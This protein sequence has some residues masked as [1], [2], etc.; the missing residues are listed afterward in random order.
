MFGRD[1]RQAE[2]WDNFIKKKGQASGMLDWKLLAGEAGGWLTRS[3]ASCVIGLG[4]IFGFLY[5]VLSWK[6]EAK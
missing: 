5:L 2:E 3:R 1:S 6:Q 4:N